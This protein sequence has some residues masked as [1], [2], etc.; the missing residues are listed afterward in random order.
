MGPGDRPHTRWLTRSVGA[1]MLRIGTSC[2]AESR[3]SAA[4]SCVVSSDHT[5][6]ST[7]SYPRS[8]AASKAY[9]A[10]RG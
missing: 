7:P 9:W 4:A 8:A 3:R 5:M 10:L 6:T 2:S 1:W